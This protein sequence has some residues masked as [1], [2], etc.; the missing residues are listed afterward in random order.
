MPK[1]LALSIARQ[2][3]G[4]DRDARHFDRLDA[5]TAPEPRA[6]QSRP[7]WDKSSSIWMAGE[8]ASSPAEQPAHARIPKA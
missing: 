5:G 4:V 2:R 3:F 1:S 7:C 8:Y 6:G